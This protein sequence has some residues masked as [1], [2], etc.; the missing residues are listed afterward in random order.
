MKICEFTFIPEDKDKPIKMV[1]EDDFKVIQ[2]GDYTIETIR[3]LTPME[4]ENM[5][6]TTDVGI[7]DCG[8]MFDEEIDRIVDRF[9]SIPRENLIPYSELVKA[10]E[11]QKNIIADTIEK[12]SEGD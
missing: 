1:Y 11:N 5:F 6:G 12:L 3:R 9:N 2:T 8:D 4:L 7:L 10:M